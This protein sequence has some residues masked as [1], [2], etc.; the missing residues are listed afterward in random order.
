MG[1]IDD[2]FR[3]TKEQQ[4]GSKHFHGMTY[5]HATPIFN[6]DSDAKVCEYID[7]YITCS[8]ESLPAPTAAIHSHKHTPT[9]G[10]HW[11]K[12]I[13]RF[14]APWY[15]MRETTLLRKFDKKT[16]EELS[17]KERKARK[18]AHLRIQSALQDFYLLS[19]TTCC[20]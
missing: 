14:N 19:E 17:K 2:L 18:E 15:P 3:I 9:C 8:S 6:R 20:Q 5:D 11:R 16:I 7:R 4:R 1:N 12:G 10:K 13:C